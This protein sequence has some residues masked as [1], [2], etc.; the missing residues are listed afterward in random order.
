MT[1]VEHHLIQYR[2]S[3]GY[4]NYA[5]PVTKVSFKWGENVVVCREKQSL[6]SIRSLE[7]ND[8]IC[9]FCLRKLNR[10]LTVIG[11]THVDSADKKIIHPTPS[12]RRR[13]PGTSP[14]LWGSLSGALLLCLIIAGI[15]IFTILGGSNGV[16]KPTQVDSTTVLPYAPSITQEATVSIIPTPSFQPTNTSQPEA[17][18]STSDPDKFVRGYF[19]AVWTD[20]NYEYLWTLSTLSF[21]N[22]AS[23]GGYDEFTKWWGSVNSI[24]IRSVNVSHNDGLYASVHVV[25]TFNLK[26]GRVLSNR[27]YDYD[28]IFDSNRG[29]WMFDSR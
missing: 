11:A 18:L 26:D 16:G 28:L 23:P 21:Q 29:V 20:R 5:D 14:V 8:Y 3:S 12:S 2:D 10:D 27:P 13:F 25:L 22:A 6:I 17:F 1:N 4:D 15:S 19:M 24:D 7:A 9:P